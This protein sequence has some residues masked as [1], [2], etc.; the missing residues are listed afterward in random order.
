MM[1]NR[2]TITKDVS[3]SYWAQPVTPRAQLYVC[4]PTLDDLL[5]RDDEIRLFDALL[6]ELDWSEWENLYPR[7]RGQPPIHP[8]LVAGVLLFCLSR[9]V[10]SSREVEEAARR[11]IDLIWFLEG[12]TIDHSTLCAFRKKFADLLPGLFDELARK[13]A[14]GPR[15]GQHLSV[16]G[17]RVRANSGRHGSRTAA[18]LRRRLGEIAENREALLA[19]MERLDALE[20][21]V[22]A[23]EE[24][25]PKA[26]RKQIETLEAQRAKLERAL[27]RA[28][29]RD[30]R[31]TE[32]PR[33]AGATRAA[34]V[35]TARSASAA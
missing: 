20:D 13:A 1:N 27:E 8:R 33:C 9:G 18:S 14:R 31:K 29:E 15:A 26:L 30:A 16:D 34:R 21:I 12:R 3:G 7:R 32:A 24:K 4:S 17:T 10:R 35:R 22:A 5:P 11:R 28:D 25:D 19:Q 23:P 2:Q 6:R